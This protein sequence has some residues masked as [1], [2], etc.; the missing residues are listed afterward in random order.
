VLFGL[1]VRYPKVSRFM[2]KQ[3][4]QSFLR[5]AMVLVLC[6]LFIACGERPTGPEKQ[7]FP[8][9]LDITPDTVRVGS[10]TMLR[11][12]GEGF[13]A[14]SRAR[15]NGQD[16]VTHF[17]S[18]TQLTLELT[19]ADVTGTDTAKVEVHNPPPGGGA[20]GHVDVFVLFEPVVVTAVTPSTLISGDTT[21]FTVTGSGFLGGA[22]VLIGTRTLGAT[23]LSSTQLV[24]RDSRVTPLPAG[25]FPLRVGNVGPNTGVSEPINVTVINRPATVTAV[26]PDSIAMDQ[27]KATI[28][29]IGKDF[30]P[31]AT[32]R[33][34]GTD[35]PASVSSPTTLTFDITSADLGSAGSFDLTVMNPISLVSNSA[36]LRV[37]QAPP[38]LTTLTPTYATYGSGTQTIT[39]TGLNFTSASAAEWNGS[40]R[41][42]TY[43]SATTM[44]MQLLAAD[45]GTPGTAQVTVH[46]PSTGLRSAS[47]AFVIMA[48]APAVSWQRTISLTTNDIVYDSIAQKLYASVPAGIAVIDPASAVVTET[49]PYAGNNPGLLAVSDDGRF[50]YTGLLNGARITRFDLARGTRDLEI[51]LPPSFMGFNVGVEDIMVLQGSPRTVIASIRNLA[52]GPRHVGVFAWDDGVRRPMS[53]QPYVGSNRITTGP[54]AQFLYGFDSFTSEYGFRRMAVTTE[55]LQDVD[56]KTSVVSIRARDIVSAGRYAYSNAGDFINLDLME[57]VGGVPILPFG[58]TPADSVRVAADVATGRVYFFTGELMHTYHS[59]NTTLI[60]S[61]SVPAARGATVMVRWGTD[62]F[63]FRTPSS[64][65]LIRSPLVGP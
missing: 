46:E 15:W 14:E 31:G 2:M 27:F 64:V 58:N 63:A 55:G 33:W 1:M 32:V 8:V 39:I 52:I 49:I 26:V 29:V 56:F 41:P 37:V 62:G 4:K 18:K 12:T 11:I 42:T 47:Q 24:A 51:D 7:P 61:I 16:R 34:R 20:S 54:T 60:G 48:G 57:R 43:V 35:R 44:R 30:V 50:L 53:T 38:R 59:V 3:M 36:P 5:Y 28:A 65:V 25:T 9:L 19:A 40:L 45:V 23:V 21:F 22:R 17:D 10:P 6:T 13:T